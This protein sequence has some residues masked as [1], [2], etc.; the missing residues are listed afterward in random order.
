MCGVLPD[1]V[2]HSHAAFESAATAQ[3]TG[4]CA[5]LTLSDSLSAV[6]ISMMSAAA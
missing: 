5:L 4:N 3:V 2:G 1:R 6:C